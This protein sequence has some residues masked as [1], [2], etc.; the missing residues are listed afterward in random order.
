MVLGLELTYIHLNQSSDDRVVLV[1]IVTGF[2]Q[3]QPDQKHKPHLNYTRWQFHVI[4]AF[5]PRTGSNIFI[6]S[7]RVLRCRRGHKEIKQ[8]GWMVL[9]MNLLVLWAAFIR[10]M[11][12][13]DLKYS[14]YSYSKSFLGRISQTAAELKGLQSLNVIVSWNVLMPSV[15]DE[16]F[17]MWVKV[18]LLVQ[19]HFA[20]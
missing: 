5:W 13:Y 10:A 16:H 17:V 6:K 19:Q 8:E 4:N 7:S 14:S 15:K 20:C 2:K 3:S 12:V 9:I 11:L 18:G 1:F